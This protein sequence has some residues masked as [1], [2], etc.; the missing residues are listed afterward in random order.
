MSLNT[1]LTVIYDSARLQQVRLLES[2]KLGMDKAPKES[3]S[4]PFLRNNFPFEICANEV[5][6]WHNA[7][8]A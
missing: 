6:V 7:D 2:V 4:I 3:V 1:I 8:I 5:K